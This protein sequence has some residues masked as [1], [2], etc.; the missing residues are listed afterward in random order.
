MK[1][2]SAIYQ[3][4][5][6]R[7]KKFAVLVDPDKSDPQR[8]KNIAISSE[9]FAVDFIFY[10]SSLLTQENHEKFI[11]II[12]DNCS[13][14]VVLFP[15][16]YL[17]INRKADGILLLSLISGRNPDLLIGKQVMAAPYLK[18]SGLE[19]IPTGYMLI[20][21]GKTTAV[22]YISNTI[23]I[24]SDKEEI[25]ICT[26]MAGE[27]LGL[28][29]IYMDGGSGA[30]NTIPASMIQKVKENIS[31]PLII[32]GGINFSSQAKEISLAGADVIVVGNAIEK[33]PSRLSELSDTIHSLN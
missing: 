14:P 25:A 32:G 6:N 9:K 22:N 27:L 11:S 4:L 3:K 15:G 5:I 31:L 16:N 12:K 10:G 24:P 8:I 29:L 2:K 18:S 30:L 21:S 33:N 7:K 28:K 26:A 1:S 19:I 17:H 23:P 13:V 20:E